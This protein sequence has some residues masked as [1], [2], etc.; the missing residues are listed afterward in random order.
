MYFKSCPEVTWIGFAARFAMR[1]SPSGGGQ[2]GGTYQGIADSVCF[3]IQGNPGIF[4]CTS[5]ISR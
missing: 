2:A 4:R 5:Y 1:L 3:R